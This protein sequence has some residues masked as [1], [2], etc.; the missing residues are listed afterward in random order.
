MNENNANDLPLPEPN[1]YEACRA[2]TLACA[3]PALEPDCV[4]QGWQNRVALPAGTNDYAVISLV[5]DA[6][7]GTTIEEFRVDEGNPDKPGFVELRGLLEVRAQIDFCGE[8]DLARQ[9]ARRLAV[10][11]RSSYGADFFKQ[12]GLSCLYAE[13]SE[14][15]VHVDEAKQFVRRYSVILRLSVWSG[16]RLEMPYFTR[17]R[18]ERLEDVPTHHNHAQNR[19]NQP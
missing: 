14:E 19:E 5:G 16:L 1:L 2:F 7:R 3:L 12:R 8:D 4:I 9:R 18:L 6:Q 17:V 11:A 10:A 15:R 13:E